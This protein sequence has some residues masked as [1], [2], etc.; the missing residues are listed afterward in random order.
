MHL[1]VAGAQLFVFT[2]LVVKLVV[3]MVFVV[4]AVAVC[5]LFYIC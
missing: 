2:P 3:V 5:A 1:K 4:I